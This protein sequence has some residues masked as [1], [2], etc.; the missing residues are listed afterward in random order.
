[1]SAS[2]GCWSLRYRLVDGRPCM[3]EEVAEQ[4]GVSREHIRQI[5]GKAL[6]TL[7]HPRHSQHLQD[8][9]SEPPAALVG[10]IDTDCPV[11]VFATLNSW[12]D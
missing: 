10:S 6:R 9:L 12:S 3:L 1:M 8:F 2:G 4:F 5:E 11:A 7:R